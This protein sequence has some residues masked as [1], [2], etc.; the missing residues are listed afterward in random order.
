M[1]E[2][3]EFDQRNEKGDAEENVAVSSFT[4]RQW[5]LR[6]SEAAVLAGLSGVAA[7]D[8]T[9]IV[10]SELSTE[11]A[12]ALP[13]GLY[14]PS[15]AHMAHALTQDQRFIT[16]PPGS[17]TEYVTPNQ[18]PFEP[19]FFSHEDFQVVRQLVRVMLNSRDEGTPPT[20]I[21]AVTEDIV[22][23]TAEWIDLTVG[24]AAAVREA[25]RSLSA[26]DRVLAEHF[27][28]EEAVRRLENDDQQ[29][30]WREGLTWLKGEAAKLSPQGYLSLTEAQQAELLSSVSDFPAGKHAD[31]AGTRF[32][33]TL[34]RRTAE[35]Y[36]TSQTGLKE[37]DYQGN[38]FHAEPPGCPQK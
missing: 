34:K 5:F 25:A 26:Q 15:A 32:Y 14:D 36:Y 27:Y 7:N 21:G 23:E 30:T 16:L 29:K 10:T 9:A 38:A 6:L 35:G 17:E 37:L 22:D 2:D 20:G 1:S 3:G 12:H 18:G 11:A 8:A 28:G 19:A 24:E 13:P 4:R 31:N 33:R